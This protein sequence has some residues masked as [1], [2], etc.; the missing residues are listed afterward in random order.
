[1]DYQ[2]FPDHYANTDLLSRLK[3]IKQDFMQ[4]NM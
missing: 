2:M 1:M 4:S 3:N